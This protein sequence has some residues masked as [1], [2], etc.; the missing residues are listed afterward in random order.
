MRYPKTAVCLAFIAVSAVLRTS[1]AQETSLLKPG[2][3]VRVTAPECQVTRQTATIISFEDKVVAAVVGERD[4]RCPYDAVEEIEISLGRRRWWKCS[5]IGLG[6]GV[7]VGMGSAMIISGS[8][9]GDDMGLSILAIGSTL[10][11]LLGGTAVGVIRGTEGWKTVPLPPVQPYLVL[12][13][14]SGLGFGLS[15]PVRR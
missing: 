3:R 8:N 13:P 2:D 10:A 7:G 14:H 5:L 1:T 6:V 11:G 4:V 12:S 9:Q 15:V